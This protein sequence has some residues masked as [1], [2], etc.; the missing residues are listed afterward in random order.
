MERLIDAQGRQTVRFEPGGEQ[1]EV[2]AE[3]SGRVASIDCHLIAR[4][5]RLAGAPMDK[6]A[7]I[8]LLR[9][10]GDGVSRGDVLYRIHAHSKS[11]LGFAIDLV[12]EDSGYGIQP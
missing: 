3:V 6:G 1:H 4:I 8:D 10:V 7:G 12:G 11:G 9:K 2:H 5:A